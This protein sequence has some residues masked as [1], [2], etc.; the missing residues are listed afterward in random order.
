[1]WFIPWEYKW[2]QIKTKN[3]KKFRYYCFG[4][5]YDCYDNDKEI[6]FED[7]FLALAKRNIVVKW[8]DT[9]DSYFK[10]IQEKAD[11]ILFNLNQ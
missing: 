8:N 10:S 5:N 9:K 4:M 7:L 1:M 11:T 2:I 3:N 6:L